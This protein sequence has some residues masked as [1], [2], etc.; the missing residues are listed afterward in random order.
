[1]TNFS[2]NASNANK[3]TIAEIAMIMDAFLA[4][5]EESEIRAL[6]HPVRRELVRLCTDGER[7]AVELAEMLELRQPR[8]ELGPVVQ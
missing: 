7:R 5:M 4:M 3:F 2:G 6:S 8:I 1:M